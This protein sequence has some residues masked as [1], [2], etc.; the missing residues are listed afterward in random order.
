[1]YTVRKWI[2]ELMLIKL[3]VKVFELSIFL[4]HIYSVFTVHSLT[5]FVRYYLNLTVNIKR[6]EQGL[7]NTS[8]PVAFY[9]LNKSSKQ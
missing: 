9:L 2:N 6:K 8:I 7:G 3:P 1:M 5:M 4:N